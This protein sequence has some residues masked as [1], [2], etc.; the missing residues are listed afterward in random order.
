V[1]QDNK[2][3]YVHPPDDR[4]GASDT[5][6]GIRVVRIVSVLMGAVALWVT[7][8]MAREVFPQ[9]PEM[10]VGAVGLAAFIP[11]YLFIS[12]AV[13]D[14]NGA[15]LC[16]ALALWGMMRMLR[17]GPTVRRCV[18]LGVALGLGWLSKLTAAALLPAAG[19]VLA[20]VALR[21]R[22]LRD[23]FRWGLLVFGVAALLIVPWLARQTLLYGEP[24]GT[25]REIVEWGL[26]QQPLTLADLGPDLYWLRTSFWG[27]L[28]YNQIPLDPWIYVALDCVTLLSLLGLLLLAIRHVRSSLLAPGPAQ[29]VTLA[30]AFLFTLG[31]MVVR[32]FLRPMPN[33]GRYL[34]PVLPAIALLMFVG[35]AAWLPRRLHRWLALGA[36]AVMGVLGMVALVCYL[37][38]AYAPPEP[39]TDAEVAAI[40]H[41]ADASLGG[42][43]RLLG[44]DLGPQLVRPEGE[45]EVTLYWQALVP[46]D[47]DYTVFVHLL[48]E[49]DLSVAQRDTYP[50]FG[51]L[52]TRWLE[53][54]FRWADR[55]TLEVPATA[56]AP[57]VAQIA[58]GLY[59]LGSGERLPAAQADGRPLGDDVRFG[60]VQV[61]PRPGE[62]PNPVEVNFGGEM[63]LVGYELSDRVVRTGTTVTLTL[64]WEGLRPM[65]DD[66]SVSVQ[67]VNENGRKAAQRDGWPADW[68]APTSE[69]E[70]GQ[71]VVD[72]HELQIYPDVPSGVYRV[73]VVVY[74]VKEEGGI[75]RLRLFSEGQETSVRQFVLSRVR[76]GP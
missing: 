42:V 5:W 23:L 60:S 48:G 62:V 52:S 21:R 46:A 43:M 37:A 51:R 73:E 1:G 6:L 70:P 61:Q 2:N 13:N 45:V 15:T 12:G 67:L 35:L 25:S 16:G 30:A 14:D 17:Q 50:G 36:A 41:R 75:R 54:G 57:D 29:I 72:A 49:G 20:L 58:V 22:S 34:F 65:T 64:F 8:R 55:Y 7:Y 9:R 63:A 66:Y 33:F 26:R 39:L 28:G 32:R 68:T 74:A 19:L 40:P 71:T 24:T 11:E 53:P 10:A 4:V 76:V 44:Y 38:P 27:R 59:D 47:R 69:W 56:Y 18:G 3:L 31:P